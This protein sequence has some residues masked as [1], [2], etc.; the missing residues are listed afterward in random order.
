LRTVINLNLSKFGTNVKLF[1]KNF[2]KFPV[3]CNIHKNEIENNNQS[4]GVV[5]EAKQFFREYLKTKGLLY[6]QQ[7]EQ[8][9]DIFL[10]TEKH[11]SIDELYSLVKRKYP[12]IGL[13]TV[14]RSIKVIC[15]AGLAR[16]ADFGDGVKRFEHKYQHQHHHHL[17]CQNC[18]KIIEITCPEIEKLQQKLAKQHDFSPSKGTIEIF[19]ICKTCKSQGK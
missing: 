10:K 18:G 2:D 12:K 7:R 1:S 6:S 3:F 16:E 4:G 11:L 19:G 13:A 8:I 17:I 9:L 15:E 14:Y 5:M